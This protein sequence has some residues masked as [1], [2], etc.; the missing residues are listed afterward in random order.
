MQWYDEQRSQQRNLCS[1]AFTYAQIIE[2][3]I[4]A[5]ITDRTTPEQ[6]QLA[7]QNLTLLCR[8]LAAKVDW[9]HYPSSSGPAHSCV[10]DVY[11]DAAFR[12]KNLEIMQPPAPAPAQQLITP[13]AVVINAEESIE[14][15]TE[16]TGLGTEDSPFDDWDNQWNVR[17][18]PKQ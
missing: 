3:T 11:A 12:L 2:Q 13:D 5:R 17:V 7:Q 18:L 6:F 8:E 4:F 9:N 1:F 16:E 14:T 10:R 15:S